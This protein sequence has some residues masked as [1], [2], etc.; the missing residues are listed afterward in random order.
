MQF[1]RAGTTLH[2]VLVGHALGHDLLGHAVSVEGDGA[3]RRGLVSVAQ[4]IGLRPL[5]LGCRCAEFEQQLSRRHV[6]A[7]GDAHAFHPRGER[8]EHRLFESR[9]HDAIGGDAR[10]PGHQHDQRGHAQDDQAPAHAQPADFRAPRPPYPHFIE[11]RPHH[12]R[13]DFHQ[14]EDQAQGLEEGVVDDHGDAHEE[15]QAVQPRRERERGE[16]A[17]ETRRDRVRPGSSMPSRR[18]RTQRFAQRPARSCR[19]G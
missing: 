10:R 13:H 14:E 7:V 17:G 11:H 1:R 5:V 8:R 19:P 16:E 12:E 9:L 2:I 3:A 4:R 15:G 18:K 6:R